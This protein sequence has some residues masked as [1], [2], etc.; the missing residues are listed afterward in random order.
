MP[1]AH[2]L[3]FFFSLF[4][5]PPSSSLAQTLDLKDH[6]VKA[7]PNR[8]F[9][10]Y[11]PEG[12]A[13]RAEFEQVHGSD[14]WQTDPSAYDY[15]A[16]IEPTFRALHDLD[17][18][19]WITGRR[20]SQGDERTKLEVIEVARDGRIKINPL[21]HWSWAQTLAYAQDNGIKYNP[22]IDR[23]YKSVGDVM[24]TVPVDPNSPERAGRWTGQGKTECGM[25]NRLSEAEQRAAKAKK[26]DGAAA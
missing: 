5:S 7:Q 2:F 11:G 4:F 19:V 21:C 23:G 9:Y 18:K 26:D 3:F 10:S 12:V 20:R 25:H 8:S 6:Y 15:L 22:L 1:L 24:T 16:K 17:V 14:L 13:N